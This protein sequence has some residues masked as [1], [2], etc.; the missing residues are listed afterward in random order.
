MARVKTGPTR[1]RRHKRL[2]SHAEGYRMAR[3][4]L[5]KSAHEAVEHAKAYAFAGRKQRKR[6]FRRAWIADLNAAARA[7]GT[8]YSRLIDT[9]TKAKKKINR[10]ELAQEL[11]KNPQSLTKLLESVK[12]D[13]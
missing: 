1:R 13:A 2:L 7:S 9:L 8:T 12:L 6:Q 4:K 3:R 5:P 11:R 10:K